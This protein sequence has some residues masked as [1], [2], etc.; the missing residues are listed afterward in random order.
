MKPLSLREQKIL[1]KKVKYRGSGKYSGYLTPREC[2][3]L[4]NS[5]VTPTFGG[6]LAYYENKVKKGDCTP[7]WFYFTA[8]SR[9]IIVPAFGGREKL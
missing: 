8:P 4:W 9:E 3:W 6:S 1:D 5:E 2:L 7:E